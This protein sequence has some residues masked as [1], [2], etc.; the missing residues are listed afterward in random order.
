MTES[1]PFHIITEKKVYQ[2]CSI[3][4][5]CDTRK[6]K[7]YGWPDGKTWVSGTTKAELKELGLEV[8]QTCNCNCV[9]CYQVD[10]A[11]AEAILQELS[12]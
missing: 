12:A 8:Y 5:Y 10:E 2:D 6:L 1:K 3:H 11:K 7:R 4:I 9:W